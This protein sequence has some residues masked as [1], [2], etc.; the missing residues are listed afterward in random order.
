M[1]ETDQDDSTDFFAEDDFKKLIKAVFES[2]LVD[3][4]K[5]QHSKNRNKKFLEESFKNSVDMFFDKTYRFQHFQ[6]LDTLT[7]DLSFLELMECILDRKNI[8]INKVHSHIIQESTD[9]WW[10]KNFHNLDV[11]ATITIGG[12][13]WTIKNS[14]NNPFIDYEN[15]RI[16]SSTNKIDSDK[17]FLTLC[18]KIMIQE[19]NINLSDEEFNK[20]FKLFYLFLKVNSPFKQRK[21]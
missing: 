4:I 9:Y 17:S 19:A 1:N 3:Y 10:N 16:Y 12:I 21:K 7:R 13:V 6:D 15:K 11:P 14:P 8:D 20:F 18:L 5:L 2:S